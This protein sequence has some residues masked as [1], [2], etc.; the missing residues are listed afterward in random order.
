MEKEGSG[1]D[2]VE[3]VA[4]GGTAVVH[5]VLNPVKSMKT[6]RIL[7]SWSLLRNKNLR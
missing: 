7:A 5:R 6:W 3:K 4:S 1:H 2:S